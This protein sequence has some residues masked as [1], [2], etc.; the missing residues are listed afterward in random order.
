MDFFSTA[1]GTVGLP[2]VMVVVFWLWIRSKRNAAPRDG[3][4]KIQRK[5]RGWLGA[6]GREDLVREE[7]RVDKLHSELSTR[8]T[9]IESGLTYQERLENLAVD[10][11]RRLHRLEQKS[12]QEIP[13]SDT[14]NWNIPRSVLRLGFRMTITDL[15]WKELGISHPEDLSN[16]QLD[17]IFQGPFCRNCLRSLV[18]QGLIDGER[19][20]RHQCRHCFHSW[21][22]DSTTTTIPLHQLKRD[23]YELLDAEYRK[24]GTIG[25]RD[26]T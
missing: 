22:V 9:N 21:R 11:R 24:S 10:L 26:E 17:K 18:A 3:G 5:I 14:N 7:E 23:L 1:L 25:I 19:S 16:H 4:G 8:L 15:I 13:E 6:V 20:V 2:V 12:S